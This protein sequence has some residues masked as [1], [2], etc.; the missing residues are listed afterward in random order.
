MLSALNAFGLFSAFRW[1]NRD[2]LII[3]NYHRFSLDIRS[4]AVSVSDFKAHLKYVKDNYNVF[5]LSDAISLVR[6][7][8]LPRNALVITIDDGYSDAYELAFP[9]LSEFE[10]PATLYCV[11]NFID[12]KGWIW[13]DLL[14]YMLSRTSKHEFVLDFGNRSFSF[15]TTGSRAESLR[16]ADKVNGKLKKLLDSDR[17]RKLT[18]FAEVLEV[19]IPSIPSSDYSPISWGQAREMD[20]N[21]LFIESHSVSHPILTRVS[22]SVLFDELKHSKTTLERELGRR[23]SHFCY[24]NGDYNEVV[25]SAARDAGYTSAVTSDFGFNAG[26]IDTFRLMRVGA[27][28]EFG[29]FIQ[30][31]TGFESFKRRL[32]SKGNI[33]QNVST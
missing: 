24:P 7:K 6:D 10:L 26:E 21:G 16:I 11:T 15:Q 3:L 19:E 18:E 13:T 5:A 14:R 8:S 31:V 17:K 12:G 20:N 22:P 29:A 9:I 25:A 2:S 32:R 27:A 33:K 4:D 30:N 1:R 28:P 23:V